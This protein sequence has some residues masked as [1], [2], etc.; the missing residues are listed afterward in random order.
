ML[1][2]ILRLIPYNNDFSCIV[3]RE[4]C[5]KQHLR[6]KVSYNPA[7]DC[8]EISYADISKHLNL[9][10]PQNAERLKSKSPCQI[11]LK[12]VY[13]QLDDEAQKFMFWHK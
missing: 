11:Y 6:K 13:W 5:S 1:R 3:I 10:F 12:P 2:Y 8:F 7:L 9:T 4:F